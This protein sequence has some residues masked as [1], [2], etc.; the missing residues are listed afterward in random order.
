MG[1]KTLWHLLLNLIEK[2]QCGSWL[3]P[4]NVR[5]SRRKMFVIKNFFVLEWNYFKWQDS[6]SQKFVNNIVSL[7]PD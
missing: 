6:N 3:V 1:I 2:D 4:G 7:K 5:H